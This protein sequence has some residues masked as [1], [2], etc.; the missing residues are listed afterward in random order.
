MENNNI[1]NDSFGYQIW[2]DDAIDW[3]ITDISNT[4]HNHYGFLKTSKA[5]IKELF[6]DVSDITDIDNRTRLKDI[7]KLI[8]NNT[9]YYLKG[10]KTGKVLFRSWVNKKTDKFDNDLICSIW[11]DTRKVD[12][13]YGGYV[14]PIFGIFLSGL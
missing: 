10:A 11:G 12:C 6:N 8:I 7:K 4:T 9:H 13:P 2:S 14:T 1:M 3:H 5:E